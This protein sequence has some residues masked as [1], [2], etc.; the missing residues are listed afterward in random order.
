M[1]HISFA[2]RQQQ[3]LGREL[4]DAVKVQLRA[5]YALFCC[6]HLS[7]IYVCNSIICLNSEWKYFYLNVCE[8]FVTRRPV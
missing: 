3:E 6:V 5:I 7:I 1:V 4:V 8:L 2:I